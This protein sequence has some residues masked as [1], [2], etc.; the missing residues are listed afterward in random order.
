MKTPRLR[1]LDGRPMT[2]AAYAAATNE[3]RRVY[4]AACPYVMPH[5]RHWCGHANC[6]DE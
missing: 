3:G 2:L 4:D 6:P 1:D 5:T